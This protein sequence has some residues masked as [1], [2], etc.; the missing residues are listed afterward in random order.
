MQSL[1]M[2]WPVAAHIGLSTITMA[3]APSVWPSASTRFISEIFSSSGQP[4][5]VTPNALFLN[6]PVFSAVPSSRSPCPGC[7]T[8]CSSSPGRARR[9]DRCRDRSA[10]SRR[11]RADALRQLEHGDAVD[12]LGLDRHEVVRI[13]LVRHLEQDAALVRRAGPP[14]SASPRRRSARRDRARRRARPRPSSSAST[15]S[16]KRSSVS[17]PPISASSSRR[18]APSV[19]RRR[20]IGRIFLGGAALHEQALDACRAAPAHRDG[21]AASATSARCRTARR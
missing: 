6:S 7:G 17:S 1:Q 8:R 5:S 2:R 14:A 15:C 16:A 3:S 18:S 19:E 12:H 11:A 21:V 10:R 9:R 13:D 20:L 4:A